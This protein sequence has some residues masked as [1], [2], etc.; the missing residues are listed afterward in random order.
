MNIAF[1]NSKNAALIE[2]KV[3]QYTTLFNK[4]HHCILSAV[5]TQFFT[6]SDVLDF[7]SMHCADQKEHLDPDFLTKS[8]DNTLQTCVNIAIEYLQA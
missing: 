1:S 4:L 8:V 6:L 2:Q 7:L 5:K 3:L